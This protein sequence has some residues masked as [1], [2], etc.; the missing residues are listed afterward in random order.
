MASRALFSKIF[1][2][3]RPLIQQSRSIK[4]TTKFALD[5]EAVKEHAFHTA[6]SSF[7]LE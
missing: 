2:R 4:Y 1:A 6:G 5:R 7:S 3:S